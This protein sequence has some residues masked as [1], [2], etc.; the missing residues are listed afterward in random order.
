MKA[1]EEAVEYAKQFLLVA[2]DGEC[3]LRQIFASEV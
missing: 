3:E 1:G 2:G